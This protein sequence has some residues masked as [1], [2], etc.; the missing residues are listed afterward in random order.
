[1]PS[2]W[3]TSGPPSPFVME[4]IEGNY[5]VAIFGRLPDKDVP[6]P[7]CVRGHLVRR[8]NPRK[9]GA[10]YGCSNWPY[11]EHT[12]RPCPACGRGLPVEAEGVSRMRRLA[13]NP[14]GQVRP[15][16]RLLELASV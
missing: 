11:C 3:P 6:C 2:S 8:E 15:L 1:M 5:D 13:A 4:L 7:T 12:Q 16:P 10:F 9:R 14:D